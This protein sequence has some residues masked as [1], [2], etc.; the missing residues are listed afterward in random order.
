[1]ELLEE[2][3]IGH[4]PEGPQYFPETMYTDQPE[5]FIVAESIREKAFLL[6]RKEV[7]Y[8]IAVEVAEFKER[9]AGTVYI[10]ASIWVEKESQK[11]ILVGKGGRT[12]KEIGRRARQDIERFLENRVYLDLWVTVKKNW[13][14]R[15]AAIKQSLWY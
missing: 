5:R 1:M 2:C 15:D 11:S 14:Q 3:L 9:K 4:L 13:T 8:S 10:G 7:P 12:L 6:L